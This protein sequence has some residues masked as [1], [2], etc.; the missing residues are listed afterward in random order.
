MER[1]FWHE[2][3]ERNEIG[4]H[5]DAVNPH[6]ERHL[7]RTS[8]PPGANI[9][10]PLCGKSLDLWWL[11]DRGFRV[12][13]VE[14]SPLA[15]RD[16]F[17]ETGRDPDIVDRNGVAV[18]RLERLEIYCGDFFAL[19]RHDLPPLQ[20]V[21]DRAAL[22]ALPPRMR[23]DYVNHIDSLTRAG[24]RTLLITLEY[25]QREM[26]GP[27]FSVPPGEVEERYSEGHRV[28]R[29]QSQDCLAAEPRFRA[30]GLS[31]LD[32]HVFLIEKNADGPD[33]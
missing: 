12:T 6:L 21:Y 26:N 13:G 5:S 30:K 1:E 24:T 14:I 20:G 32:E 10:V 28:Q 29:L 18:Y 8:W 17:A 9:L 4:F 25:L 31:R 27:P 7:H 23:A 22:V 33:S 3:W 19:G 15:V 11:R 16:F 2:R